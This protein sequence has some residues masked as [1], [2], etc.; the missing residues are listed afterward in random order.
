MPARLMINWSAIDPRSRRGQL[1]RLPARLL[2][3]SAVMHIRHGPARGMRWISGSATHGC[4]LGTYELAKQAL[5]ARLVRPGMTVYDIGAQAGFYTLI[6]SRLVGPSGHVIA[7]EPCVSELGY[8]LA[9]VK[10]NALTN[11][12]VVQ[13]A[14]GGDATPGGF[15]Y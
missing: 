13:A 4:W 7:F 6:F 2:P 9:H 10:L 15:L 1:I 11:I 12:R 3:K 8:L 5:V 14:V